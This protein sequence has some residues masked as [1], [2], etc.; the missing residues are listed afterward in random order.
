MTASSLP[1]RMQPDQERRVDAVVSFAWRVL[2]FV[3]VVAALGALAITAVFH[4]LGAI[5]QTQAEGIVRGYKNRTPDCVA[6]LL[7]S[8]TRLPDVCTEKGVLPYVCAAAAQTNPAWV[9]RIEAQVGHPCSL[10]AS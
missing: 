7:S 4:R 3:A 5:Q 10:P 1:P 2:V 9:Q 6:L 8:A